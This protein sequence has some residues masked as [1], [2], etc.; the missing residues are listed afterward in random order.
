MMK[1]IKVVYIESFS[2]SFILKMSFIASS[3]MW[4]DQAV[5]RLCQVI[6]ESNDGMVQQILENRTDWLDLLSKEELERTDD[7]GLSLP[8]L[9]AYYDKP[10]AI[11][12]LHKRGF[13]LSLPC[14]PVGFGNVMYYAVTLGKIRIVE[15]LDAI[16]YSVTKPCETIFQKNAIY[17]AGRKD[18]I[19]LMELLEQIRSREERAHSLFLKN[20]LK[21]KYRRL[22]LKKKASALK[23]QRVTRGK[24]S[25]QL[26]L[27]FKSGAIDYDNLFQ[28]SGSLV[29]SS[30]MSVLDENNDE[31][32]EEEGD[33]IQNK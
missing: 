23:I 20:F 9:A 33:I 29:E 17:Y 30:Q 14:D 28:L 16:G 11:R 2:K 3:E 22:Y 1:I 24:I 7:L 6:I 13:D 25:R 18:D 21:A 5:A 27:A 31:E 19:Y 10:D 8:F 15:T 26:F 4:G 12:Y 32:D